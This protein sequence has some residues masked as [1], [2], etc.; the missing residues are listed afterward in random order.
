MRLGGSGLPGDEHL[1]RSRCRHPRV[2]AE[3]WALQ[4]CRRRQK[5]WEG[6]V[7]TDVATEAAGPDGR[8]D[9]Y[10][11]N[12]GPAVPLGKVAVDGNPLPADLRVQVESAFQ[13]SSPFFPYCCAAII[14]VCLGSLWNWKGNAPA[15]LG[16]Q[17]AEFSQLN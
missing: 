14:I 12:S 16:G 5:G 13:T 3:D 2:S 4:S 6:L 1:G 7:P 15:P 8:K 10:M 9:L 17:A 11:L